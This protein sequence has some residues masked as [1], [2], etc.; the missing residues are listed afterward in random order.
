GVSAVALIIARN[1]GI[2]T[3]RISTGVGMNA[4][5]PVI[6]V[7]CR[8][9]VPTAVMRFQSVMIPAISGVPARNDNALTGVT[10]RPNLWRV[11]VVDARLDRCRLLRF[12]RRWRDCAGLRQDVMNFWITL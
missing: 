9:A 4:V 6:I 3:A 2:K 5:M 12:V 1:G 8:C 7:I 10:H 11:G